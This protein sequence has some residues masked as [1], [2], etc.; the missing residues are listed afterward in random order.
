MAFGL[1]Q[2]IVPQQPR[3]VPLAS[4]LWLLLMTIPTSAR[5]QLGSNFIAMVLCL[6]HPGS[7]GMAKVKTPLTYEADWV[8]RLTEPQV[9][10]SGPVILIE[11]DVTSGPIIEETTYCPERV[12]VT[13]DTARKFAVPQIVYP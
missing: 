3:H 9:T 4:Q 6:L 10:I 7:N 8:M 13:V 12:C 5:V 11:A 1:V 2:S